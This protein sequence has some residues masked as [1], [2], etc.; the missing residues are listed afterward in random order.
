MQSLQDL[1][2]AKIRK[3]YERFMPEKDKEKDEEMLQKYIN[4]ELEEIADFLAN[5]LDDLIR[6]Y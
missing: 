3:N 1:V 5:Q 4:E 6:R 2:T